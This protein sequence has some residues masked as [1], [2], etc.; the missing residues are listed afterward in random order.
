[1]KGRTHNGRRLRNLT[2]IDEARRE[3]VG[4]IIMRGPLAH[5][6]SDVGG[7][8]I[9]T[10]LERWLA[11]IGVTTLAI[12]IG[13]PWHDGNPNFFNGSLHRELINGNGKEQAQPGF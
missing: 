3:C 10:A 12:A 5:I 8:F 13:R 11:Q 2:I 1:V 9:A 7:E 4:L 6:R